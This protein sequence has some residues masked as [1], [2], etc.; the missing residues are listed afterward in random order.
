MKTKFQPLR[1]LNVADDV[2]YQ[3]FYEL[4][5]MLA[6]IVRGAIIDACDY[7]VL[8]VIYNGGEY[9]TDA[10]NYEV[11]MIGELPALRRCEDDV[12]IIKF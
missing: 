8:T 1:S 11:G 5:E 9:D 4:R 7:E 6:T 10:V 12:L 3:M 2:A